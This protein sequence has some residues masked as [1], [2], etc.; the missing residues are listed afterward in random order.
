MSRT[1][2]VVGYPWHF[3]SVTGETLPYNPWFTG[4]DDFELLSYGKD[5]TLI[6]TKHPTQ[7]RVSGWVVNPTSMDESWSALKD[8]WKWKLVHKYDDGRVVLAGVTI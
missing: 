6:L 4:G 7:P 5:G 2:T 8:G 3:V 1:A